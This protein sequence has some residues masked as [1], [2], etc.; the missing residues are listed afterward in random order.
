MAKISSSGLT[1]GLATLPSKNWIVDGLIP[2]RIRNIRMSKAI[3]MLHSRRSNILSRAIHTLVTDADN[4]NLIF[5]NVLP[6]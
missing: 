4:R 5:R 3:K 2:E 1:P 6:T